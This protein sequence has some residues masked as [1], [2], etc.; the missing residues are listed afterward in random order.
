MGSNDYTSRKNVRSFLSLFGSLDDGTKL[1]IA[2]SIKFSRVDLKPEA[3][4]NASYGERDGQ[5]LTTLE[6]AKQRTSHTRPPPEAP[7]SGSSARTA[8]EA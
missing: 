7:A 1:T 3:E 6:V 2:K 5:I 4:V 8:R